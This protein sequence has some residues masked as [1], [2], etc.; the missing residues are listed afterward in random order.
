MGSKYFHFTG[1]A[2]FVVLTDVAHELSLQV[3]HRGEDAAGDDVALDLGEPELDLVQPG[4][5]RRSEVQVNIGVCC[6]EFV[7]RLVLC[8]ERLSAMTWISLPR[9]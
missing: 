4:R 7:D 5:V 1:L 3:G 6:E 8:A 2:C 9:G